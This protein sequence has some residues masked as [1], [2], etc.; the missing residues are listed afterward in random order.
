[1]TAWLAE[2]SSIPSQAPDR[3]SDDYQ[4]G[5]FRGVDEGHLLAPV[6]EQ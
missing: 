4:P 2:P 6:S 5:V 1:M 3:E